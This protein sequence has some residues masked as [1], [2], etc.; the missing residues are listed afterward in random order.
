MPSLL[1]P[2]HTA[3]DLEEFEERAALLEHTGGF[4][5]HM[6]ERLAARFVNRKIEARKQEQTATTQ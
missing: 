5:R 6:A 2:G 4:G 3:D 1:A